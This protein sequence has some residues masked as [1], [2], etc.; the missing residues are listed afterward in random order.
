MSR[1]ALAFLL[2]ACAESGDEGALHLGDGGPGDAAGP[3]ADLW[4]DDARFGPRD[5]GGDPTDAVPPDAAYDLDSTVDLDAGEGDLDAN[6][7]P[8]G[9]PCNP[10]PIRDFPYQDMRD[11]TASPAS[12]IDAYSCAPDIDES[13]DEFYYTFT[14]DEPG[15]LSAQVDDRGGDDVD[16][17]LHVLDDFDPDTC[18][19]RDN[20][21]IR[22]LLHPGSYVLVVDT[23]VNGDGRALPGPYTLDVDFLPTGGDPC[24]TMQVDLRMVW[25]ACDGSLDC[26]ERDGERFLRTPAV[27]PLVKEAHLVTPADGFGDGWPSS[28]RDGI[29]AHYALSEAATDYVMDRREPWAPAGEGGSRW[30]QGSTGRPV[31]VTDEAWYVNMYWRDRPAPGTRMILRNPENGRAVVASAGYET[32]PGAN[33]AVGGASEE[34]HDW[35]GTRHR[36]IALL[37]F[38]ADDALPLGPI[39]CE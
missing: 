1:V 36:S 24:A 20:R 18:R 2:V 8:L 19:A 32:G 15:V 28:G 4:P 13:G 17:D 33:T 37:G 29:D 5:F 27:G 38:A 10:I 16:V 12:E 34:I 31:P 23:W 35:L 3:R 39:D 26:F 11:T 21:T 6:G 9:A 30:G 25:R 7:C 14:V 22:L